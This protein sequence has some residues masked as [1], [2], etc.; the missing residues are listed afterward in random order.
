MSKWMK[1]FLFTVVTVIGIVCIGILWRLYSHQR[2]TGKWRQPKIQIE[3][4]STLEIAAIDRKV[5]SYFYLISQSADLLNPRYVWKGTAW[6]NRITEKIN[7]I[8]L[9]YETVLV[10]SSTGELTNLAIPNH[11]TALV[12]EN[13]KLYLKAESSYYSESGVY[14]VSLDSGAIDELTAE[15]FASLQLEW[16]PLDPLPPRPPGIK[17]LY[18]GIETRLRREYLV[19]PDS[20]NRYSQTD[21]PD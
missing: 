2:I 4:A 12:H 16:T 8:A 15:Q 3:A 21:I 20:N 18:P 17:E 1:R 6:Q 14:Q 10:E 19:E 9:G 5:L 7:R 13:A 11:V